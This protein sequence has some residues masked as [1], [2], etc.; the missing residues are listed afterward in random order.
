MAASKRSKGSARGHKKAVKRS[1]GSYGH[2]KPVK[3]SK[4]SA[5]KKVVKRSKGSAGGKKVLRK[6]V[7]G[8]YRQGKIDGAAGVIKA[9]ARHKKGSKRSRK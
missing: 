2:K 9:A 5:H 7:K 6:V 4:G 1:K 3:R 8:A